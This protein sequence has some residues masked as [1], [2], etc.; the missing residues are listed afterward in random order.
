MRNKLDGLLRA[1]A[2]E[3]GASLVGVADLIPVREY[4]RAQGGDH[5]ARYPRVVSLGI[6]LPSDI[7]DLNGAD[8]LN[9]VF[10]TIYRGHGYDVINPRLDA[11]ASRVA[12]LLQ[13]QGHRVFPIRAAQRRSPDQLYGNFSHKLGA[14]LAG[15]GWIG[16]SCLLV[17]PEYGPRIRWISVL[18]EAPLVPGEPMDER[19][20]DCRVCVDACPAHAFTGRR[21]VAEEPR[22]ARCRA[23][24]C[25]AYQYTKRPG[26]DRVLCG[27][28]LYSCPH[29]R[30]EPSQMAD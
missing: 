3:W 14:H 20:G 1:R 29:G 11:L 21:F 9:P 16:K 18:T 22:E 6:A 26:L 5:I 30:R 24:E 7:V 28:C 2:I 19:C 8:H 25:E 12:S 23:E 17:T 10:A 27:M 15:L 4:V 13:A